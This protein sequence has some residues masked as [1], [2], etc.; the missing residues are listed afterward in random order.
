MTI[1][2]IILC[3]NEE[4]VIKSAIKSATWAKETIVVITNS[5]DKSINI[6]KDT[7]PKAKIV[8][9]VGGSFS[10]WRNLGLS[11]ASSQW[12]LYLDADEIITPQ[13]KKAI[14]KEIN[15]ARIF[16]YFAI[17]RK[18]YFLG[19]PVKFGNSYP[20]YQKRL[21]LKSKIKKW[22]GDLH[23]Y[24]QVHGTMGYIQEPILHNTHRNLFDMVNKTDNWT[25]LQANNLFLNHHPTMAT[26]RIFRMFITKFIE[27]FFIQQMYRD[28]TVGLITSLFESYD[29]AIIYSKLLEKQK[30]GK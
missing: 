22:E 13:L 17:S 5:T 28:K 29:T 6:I 10:D 11:Y 7:N 9:N 2:I 14:L 8:K 20:D 23:E 12:V 26:W 16:T 3:G 4:E 1:S 24:P 15:Q 27:K 25:N 18:N 21:F 19:Y 30:Y